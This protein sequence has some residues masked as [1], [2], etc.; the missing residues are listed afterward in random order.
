MF[1]PAFIKTNQ[2]SIEKSPTCDLSVSMLFL[3]VNLHRRQHDGFFSSQHAFYIQN[4]IILEGFMSFKLPSSLEMSHQEIHAFK[5]PHFRSIFGLF[6]QLFVN[7]SD[8]KY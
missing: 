6:F 7:K 3:L 4:T 1:L 5:H 8:P 2:G